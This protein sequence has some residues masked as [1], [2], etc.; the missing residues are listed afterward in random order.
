MEE[1][2]SGCY[3]LSG[4]RDRYACIKYARFGSLPNNLFG[5]TYVSITRLEH[6]VCEKVMLNYER[7]IAIEHSV[8]TSRI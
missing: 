3:S 4:E 2:P 7:A 8:F 6:I 5:R 1:C